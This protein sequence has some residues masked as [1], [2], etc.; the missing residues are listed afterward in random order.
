V[1]ESQ[2]DYSEYVP[3][4]SER[5]EITMVIDSIQFLLTMIEPISAECISQTASNLKILQQY[6]ATERMEKN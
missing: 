5:I 2:S 6:P 3:D 1:I 4:T